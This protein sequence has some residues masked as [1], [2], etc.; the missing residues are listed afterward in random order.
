VTEQLQVDG[1]AA[2][3]QSYD[4]LLGSLEAKELGQGRS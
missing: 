3:A 2:F 1:V 4:A